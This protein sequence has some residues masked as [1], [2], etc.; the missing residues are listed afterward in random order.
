MALLGC[1]KDDR[2]RT[3][4]WSRSDRLFEQAGSWHFY[5][6][7]GTVEGPYG[8]KPRAKERLEVY[9]ALMQAGLSTK[10]DDGPDFQ[11]EPM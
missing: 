9:V 7:E 11:L 5:T 6:R 4:V 10:R 2:P 1:R 8:S 3:R